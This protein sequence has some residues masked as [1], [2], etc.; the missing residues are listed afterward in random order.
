M[1]SVIKALSRKVGSIPFFEA[2]EIMLE[3]L[4]IGQKISSLSGGENIRIKILK[5]ASFFTGLTS[6][7]QQ[8][9]FPK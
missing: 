8:G 9:I 4:L 3:Y 7:F 5:E 6:L 1:P 2:N